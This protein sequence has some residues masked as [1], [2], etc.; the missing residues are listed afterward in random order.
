[1]AVWDLRFRDEPTRHVLPGSADVWQVCAALSLF[2]HHDVVH[3]CRNAVGSL[4]CTQQFV[5]R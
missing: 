2:D 1:M 5:D 4:L 3:R